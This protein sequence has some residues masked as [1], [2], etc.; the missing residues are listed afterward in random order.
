M[1]DRY[2]FRGKRADNGKYVVGYYIE[3][4]KRD[5]TGV[6]YL[7]IERDADG[8]SHL[9]IPE[10]VGQCTGL[11]DKNGKLIFEG[12]IFKYTSIASNEKITYGVVKY[13]TT[14]EQ[15]R[16][17][18]PCGYVI[19]WQ[20]NSTRRTLRQDLPFWCCSLSNAE[21]CGNIHDNPELL[22]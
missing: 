10:S 7:I 11:K 2:L 3:A 1:N 21:L 9:I 16:G 12:D 20:D 8:S 13:R 15:Y 19:Y 17:H 18:N 6:E 4:E 22:R 5:K 14:Y